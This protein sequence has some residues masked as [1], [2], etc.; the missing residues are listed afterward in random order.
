MN[1]AHKRLDQ[2]QLDFAMRYMLAYECHVPTLLS[3]AETPCECIPEGFTCEDMKKIMA[4]IK[5]WATNVLK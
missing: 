2:R 1:D 3:H 4:F 5:Y